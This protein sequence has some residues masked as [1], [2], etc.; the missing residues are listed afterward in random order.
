LLD[1]KQEIDQPHIEAAL[2]VWEYCEVSACHIFG[3]LLGDPVADDILRALNGAEEMTRTNIRDY[4]GRNE[5]AGRISAALGLL[6]RK[7]L[8]TME[9]RQSG[10]GRPIEIWRTTKHD[11]TTKG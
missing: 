10:G 7:G 5:S 11:I 4:F 1:G 9:E 8:A 2:A 6:L 3:E